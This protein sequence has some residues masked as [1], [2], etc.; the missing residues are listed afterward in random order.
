MHAVRGRHVQRPRRQ[1]VLPVSARHLWRGRGGQLHEDS[2]QHIHRRERVLAASSVRSPQGVSN[3]RGDDRVH[4]LPRMVPGLDHASGRTRPGMPVH[5]RS[6][7]H[8]PAAGSL[9]HPLS[10]G[11]LQ[12]WCGGGGGCAKCQVRALWGRVLQLCGVPLLPMPRW[13]VPTIASRRLRGIPWQHVHPRH[14]V[15]QRV[16]LLRGH[17]Q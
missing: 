6:R 13:C 4:V 12:R 10:R 8:P 2:Y 5:L 9:L 17:V 14:G 15:L 7:L 16:E 1:R 11:H 3:Q